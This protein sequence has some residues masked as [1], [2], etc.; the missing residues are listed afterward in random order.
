MLRFVFLV[1]AVALSTGQRDRKLV[2]DHIRE[3][4]NALP[5]DSFLRH[6]LEA[7]ARGDGIH[8]LWMDEMKRESVKRAVV[9][10][11]IQ[12]SR[13]GYPRD[14]GVAN[15][16]YYDDYDSISKQITD[17]IRLDR[18]RASGV[19]RDLRK[20]AL[21]RAAH[22]SWVDVPRPRAKPFVGGTTVEIFDDEWLPVVPPLF[23]ANA[24]PPGHP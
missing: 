3:I 23:S 10:I 14:M 6:E 2:E 22:G 21:E 19:E 7:G 4:M 8:R 15:V 5:V 16:I 1:L 17:Q 24:S 20:A 12:F 11:S 18:I 9:K 13:K